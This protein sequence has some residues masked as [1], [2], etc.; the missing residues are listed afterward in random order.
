L[1]WTGPRSIVS[2][3]A[4]HGPFIAK[5]RAKV[6]GRGKMP[7]G[8]AVTGLFHVLVKTNDLAETLGF[9]TKVLG[10]HEVERPAFGFPGAWLSCGAGGII[11]HVW[12]GGP[13]FDRDGPTPDGTAT[14]DH[15]SL[16]AKGHEGF[17]EKF[18]AFGLP[19]REF[20]IPNTTLFQ[21]F[22]YDPSGVQIELTFDMQD[23]QPLDGPVPPEHLYAPADKFFDRRTYPRFT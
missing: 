4:P 10:L 14:I 18:R 3:P 13:L 22:V 2:A 9:Y 12:S 23:E 20:L 16:T 21:L 5:P 7:D 8:S 19:W 6:K 1:G 11:I 17:R 15:V